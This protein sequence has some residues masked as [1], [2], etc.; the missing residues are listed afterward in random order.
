MNIQNKKKLW[1]SAGSMLLAAF[2]F[3]IIYKFIPVVFSTND[4]RMIA[5]IVSG[6]YTGSPESYG[7]QMSYGLTWFLSCLY[8]LS[9]SFQWYGIVLIAVQIF[10]FGAVLYRLQA[11]FDGWQKKVMALLA[12]AAVYTA[13]WLNVYVQMTYTTTAAFVGFAAMFWYALSDSKYRNLFMT[14]LLANLAFSIRPNVFYMLIPVTGII[15]LWKLIGKK[16]PGR[17][18]VLA[19]FIILSVTAALFVVDAAAYAKP[20]WKEFRQFF[21]ERTK[22]YDYYGWEDYEEHPELY[23]PYGI[24]EEEYHLLKIYDYSVLGNLPKEFFPQYIEAY[25]KM[26]QAEGITPFKKLGNAFKTFASDVLH[27]AYGAC[28]TILFLLAAALLVILILKKNYR[29]AVYLAVQCA[30]INGLWLY[31][32][33]WGRAIDRIQITMSLIFLAV[34]MHVLCEMYKMCRK[35]NKMW[36]NAAA[37]LCMVVL[38]FLAGKNFLNYRYENIYKAN[39]YTDV[40]LL[41]EFCAEHPENRYFMDIATMT[42]LYGKFTIR[43]TEPEEAHYLLLGD[44]SAF[45]PHDM[46]KRKKYGIDDVAEAILEEDSYVIMLH[47]YQLRCMKEYLGVEESWEDTVFG[48]N[49]D[50]YA[51]Y[52]MKAAK[53]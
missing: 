17:R 3:M 24:S 4:D 23:E 31:F 29:L 15:Y 49:G 40:Q 13:L 16:E 22:I 2:L 28:N 19:P 9:N 37:S 35:E 33:Y 47:N 6:Q 51:V 20:E 39:A 48:V 44:W 1:E 41:K 34:I 36:I 43:R 11:I 30:V 12:A 42:D 21:D 14:G 10:S 32:T 52:K 46:K 25:Q 7:I 45:S 38:L 27:Q 26:E 5:E 18:T 8:K 50:L 53:Q